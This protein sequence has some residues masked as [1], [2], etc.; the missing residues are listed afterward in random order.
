MKTQRS[1]PRR[2]V[3][4]ALGILA[5]ASLPTYDPNR[6]KT[7]NNEALFNRAMAHQIRGDHEKAIADLEEQTSRPPEQ[8]CALKPQI[9]TLAHTI[10]CVPQHPTKRHSA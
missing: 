4:L 3:L 5:L 1:Q 6:G 7:I 8:P 2:I 9:L 10:P